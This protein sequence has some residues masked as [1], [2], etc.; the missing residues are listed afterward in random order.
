MLGVLRI[1]LGP[2]LLTQGK[3]VRRDILR[4]PE[5]D[6]ARS[7]ILG[8]GQPLSL[9]LLGDSAMAGVG[10]ATQDKALSGKLVGALADTNQVTWR[11]VA[12][13]GWTTTDGLDALADLPDVPLQV[14]MISLGV[15]DVTTEQPVDRFL[16]RY[17]RIVTRIQDGHGAKL[18]IV[19]A[20]PPMN[21]FSALPQPLRWYL[22]AR[23]RMYDHALAAWAQRQEGVVHLTFDESLEPADLAEDGFHPGPNVYQKW[24]EKAAMVIRS[25]LNR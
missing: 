15:N 14:A 24:A 7:G 25:A 23:A 22:G 17:E 19:C 10:V 5:P 18:V 12:M 13:T 3:R 6:G 16:S 11:L 9:L 21:K 8:S 20:L 2:V 1:L 4:M